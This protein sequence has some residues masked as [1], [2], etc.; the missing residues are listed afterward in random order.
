MNAQE[1][2]RAW[3]EKQDDSWGC[4]KSARSVCGLETLLAAY[5]AHKE[6]W[7]AVEEVL[8]SSNSEVLIAIPFWRSTNDRDKPPEWEYK[9]GIVIAGGFSTEGEYYGRD[10]VEAWRPLPAPP[11]CSTK[12]KP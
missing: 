2:A 9:T 4:I 10:E 1:E 8:P 7:I 11:D 5:A 12:E 6:R 3:L